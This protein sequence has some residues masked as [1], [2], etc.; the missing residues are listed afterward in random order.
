MVILISSENE[1]LVVD[2]DIIKS[3]VLVGSMLEGEHTASISLRYLVSKGLTA[4]SSPDLGDSDE[5]LQL[6][7]VSSSVLKR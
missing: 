4:C 2:K 1:Q 3:G 6:H 5:A 7:N